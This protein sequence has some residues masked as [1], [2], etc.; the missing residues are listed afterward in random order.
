MSYTHTTLSKIPPR[1]MV[2]CCM[3]MVLQCLNQLP[4]NNSVYIDMS[5]NSIVVGTSKPDYEEIKKLNF[6]D[7]VQAHQPSNITNDNKSRAVGAITLYPQG[8]LQGSW[9][10]I[11]FTTGEQ[12]HIHQWHVLPIST[13]MI[14][15]VHKEIEEG[16][17]LIKGNFEFNSIEDDDYNNDFNEEDHT[18]KNKNDKL[19]L[20]TYN[21]DEYNYRLYHD[22]DINV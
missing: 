1:R 10:L 6:G 18:N 4:D 5:T 11:S 16:Q 19:K 8:N 3:G 20:I 13:D 12:I 7:Y 17:P 2:K 15:R 14:D 21:N 22:N 9:Y